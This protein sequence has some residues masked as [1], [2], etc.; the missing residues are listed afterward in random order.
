MASVRA[1]HTT[2]GEDRVKAWDWMTMFLLIGLGI[3]SRLPFQSTILHHW[4]SVNFALALE[5]FDVRL[6]QPHPPGTFLVYI[7]VGRLFNLFLHNPN[8]SL[9]WV[10]IIATGLAMAAI[11]ILG[12]IWFD[13]RTGLAT[14]LLIVTSPLVWFHG[15]VALSY[16]LEFLWVLMI[17]LACCKVPAGATKALYA[18]ALLLGL[19]GGIRPNTPFFLFPLWFTAV[20][21]GVWARKYSVRNL[22][23]ALSLLATGVGLWAIPVVIMSG[24]PA[25]YWHVLESWRAEHLEEGGMAARI[26]RLGMI[27]LYGV[28]AGL[29]PVGWA[30]LRE[31]RVLRGNL[32]H[33]RRTQAFALWIGP[34]LAYF[35]FIHLRQSGQT[36]TIVP[37]FIIIAGISTVSVGGYLEWLNRKAWVIV[38][39]FV[40]ICNGVFFL[41]GPAYRFGRSADLIF[42]PPTWAAIRNYDTEIERRLDVIRREFTPEETVVI[43]G[44]RNFRLPDFYLRDY[45]DTSLYA[46]LGED[47]I[48]LPSKVHTLVLFD[49]D[50]FPEMSVKS[51]L[52][53]LSLPGGGSIRYIRW[54]D[55]QQV[56]MSES[57]FEVQKR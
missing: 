10:S 15:E 35:I 7:L 25:A 30:L 22:A 27:T 46:R 29:I 31:W 45:Q 51:G 14:A 33:D 56:R 18:S 39:A 42:N 9:V 49:D 40:V 55:D 57:S 34:A 17:I 19:S 1:P 50:V 4:D 12:T 23:V 8:A 38:T 5:H 16:Q 32:L 24:G 37:A 13:R 44:P 43:A 53:L 52:R 6:H 26:A 20:G 3:V 48:V 11:F 28:G 47:A 2:K 41:F 21:S 54:N 36:F